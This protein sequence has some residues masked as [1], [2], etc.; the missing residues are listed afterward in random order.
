VVV[1]TDHSAYDPAMIVRHAKRVFDTRNLT[2][3]H[4]APHVFRL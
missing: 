1:H 3:E 2:A 4:P